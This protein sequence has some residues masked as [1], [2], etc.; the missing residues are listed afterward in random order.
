MSGETSEYRVGIGYD[1]H[2]LVRGRDLILGGVRIPHETGLE[3]H[4]D[5]DALCH[6]VIDAILGALGLGDVGKH[7]PDT[8]PA[9]KNADSLELLRKVRSFRASSGGWEIVNVDAVVIAESP[10][11][12]LYIPQMCENLARILECEVKR[13]NVKAKTNERLDALGRKEGIAAQA[14]VGLRIL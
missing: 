8:D 7:F 4:S 3:G 9:F 13:V 5:A 1:I 14:V 6:A 10:R 2:R 12:S 11:L